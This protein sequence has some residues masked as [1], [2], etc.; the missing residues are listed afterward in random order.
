MVP[1][2]APPP[3]STLLLIKNC[4]LTAAH[5][6]VYLQ[7]P[8]QTLLTKSEYIQSVLLDEVRHLAGA[9]ATTKSCQRRIRIRQIGCA[10]DRYQKTFKVILLKRLT[11]I[12]APRSKPA[13]LTP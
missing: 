1:L 9:I 5:P 13:M 11:V 2:P 8:K 7:P 3:M 12:S 4:Q 10:L 6:S